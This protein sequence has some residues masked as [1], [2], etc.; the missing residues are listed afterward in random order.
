MGRLYWRRHFLYHSFFP[1]ISLLPFHVYRS[2][3]R[4]S[5]DSGSIRNLG[6]F[7]GIFIKTPS[8]IKDSG[9]ILPGHGG[10]LDRFDSAILAIPA[11]VVY[12]YVVSL[13]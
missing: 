7:N 5:I 9:N 1:A 12:L 2:M 13:F 4:T 8:R 6:R 10:M 11:A 3:D